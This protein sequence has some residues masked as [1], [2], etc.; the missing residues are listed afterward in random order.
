M[1]Y[2]IETEEFRDRDSSSSRSV[3]HDFYVFFFLSCD[4]QRIDQSCKDS[5]SC[6]VLIIMHDRDIELRLES[7]FDLETPWC[8]D[9]FEIDPSESIGDI[10]HSFDKLLDILRP[11]DDRE[12]I[13]SCEFFKEYTLPFHD[14][15][16]RSVSEI[17]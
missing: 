7:L 4:F 2:P 10:F 5:D 16:A 13:D 11:D 6:P 3:E 8:C 15:H 9:I 1:L 12:S 14:R 17:S